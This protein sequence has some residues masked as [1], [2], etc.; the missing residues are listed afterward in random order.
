MQTH[1]RSQGTDKDQTEPT[2]ETVS[3]S[4]ISYYTPGMLILGLGLSSLVLELVALNDL[5]LA[6]HYCLKYGMCF[7]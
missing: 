6:I 3:L 1:Y 2:F 4:Q 5:A 7:Y